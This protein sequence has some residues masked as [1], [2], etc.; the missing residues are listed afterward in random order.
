MKK[1][2]S[3]IIFQSIACCFFL[4]WGIALG[5]ASAGFWVSLSVFLLS[6]ITFF[7]MLKDAK[8]I[9]KEMRRYLFAFCPIV[10]MDTF[11]VC[12]WVKL[13]ASEFTWRY[14]ALAVGTIGFGVLSL[15]LIAAYRKYATQLKSSR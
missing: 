9:D 8:F 15:M 7:V 12:A 14:I 3:Q 1:W 10:L 11:L 5:T 2:I 4:G 13:L 6:F